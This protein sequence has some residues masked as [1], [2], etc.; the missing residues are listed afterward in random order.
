MELPVLLRQ[1]ID[2]ALEGVSLAD[3]TRAA[4]LL[5]ERYRG[6]MRDD[7]WHLSDDLAAIAHLAAITLRQKGSG[8]RQIGKRHALE[9]L[10]DGLAQEDRKFH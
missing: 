7:R 6:E 4:A 10:V 2:H 9:R 5:S 3:L 1:A 8:T